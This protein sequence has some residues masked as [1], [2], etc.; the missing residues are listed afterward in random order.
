MHYVLESERANIRN[1]RMFPL[2]PVA[3]VALGDNQVLLQIERYALTANTITYG[4]VGDMLGYWQFFPAESPYGRIPAWGIAHVLA[5]SVD[6]LKQG[7]R[8]YGYFPMSDRLVVEPAQ[9]SA[10]GF[11]DGAAH[12]ASLPP[13]YNRYSRMT[14]ENGFPPE[15]D[16]FQIVLRPLFMTSFSID[17]FLEA[18]HY[19]GA[20]RVVVVSASSKTA[21]SLAFCMQSNDRPVEVIGLT[22]KGNRAF[23]E[24]TGLYDIV[25]DYD[26]L[27][28]I[29]EDVETVV[30]DMAGNAATCAE[31]RRRFGAKLS[32]YCS[33]GLTHWQASAPEDTS[34]LPGA[35]P[36]MYFAP[37]EIERLIGSWG[38]EQFARRTA[39]SWMR[40]CD[41]ARDWLRIEAKPADDTLP[42]HYLE[43]ADGM[44]PDVARVI[45]NTN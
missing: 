10:N 21:L 31:L 45:V 3:D 29:A 34:N 38:G 41:T 33:V 17:T 11:V 2:G 25:Y 26:A 15:Q 20:K 9:V 28:A 14:A 27:S 8:F 12:R 37:T 18:N 23:V 6:G 44:A 5:G 1:T 16:D 7:D 39:D 32:Y 13:I 40:L 19:F 4:V 24:R 30:V 36:V 43:V 22:S 35:E 42:M